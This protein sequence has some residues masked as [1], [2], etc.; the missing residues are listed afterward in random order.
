[1][2]EKSGTCPDCGINLHLVSDPCCEPTCQQWCRIE[3]SKPS[4][5]CAARNGVGTNDPQ[6]C[7]WPNCGCAP[8]GTGSTEID[9]LALVIE[10]A[11]RNADPGHHKEVLAALNTN[12]MNC[13][14][15]PRTG[16]VTESIYS[17][18]CVVVPLADVQH[19]EKSDAGLIV[20]TKH[21]KWDREANYWANNIWIDGAEASGFLS[22]WCRYR[23]ELEADTLAD[24]MPGASH[25]E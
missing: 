20:V 6:D 14:G 24:L 13:L 12:R 9:R 22:A 18:K 5:K 17:G 15:V 11:V 1:M 21:T 2:T 4:F 7:D 8:S 3:V 19:V 10:S 25:A 23:S 16:H